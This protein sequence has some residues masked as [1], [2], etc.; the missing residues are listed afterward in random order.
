[1]SIKVLHGLTLLTR[2]DIWVRPVCTHKQT[3]V[4]EGLCGC[5]S[6]VGNMN[7]PVG[8]PRFS[9]ER[10][11]QQGQGAAG[12]AGVWGGDILLYTNSIAL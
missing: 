7:I 12:G 6:P 4:L 3:T 11:E 9:A 5:A 10:T 2:R 8:P 1:M